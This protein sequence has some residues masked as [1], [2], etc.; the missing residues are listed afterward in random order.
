MIR[1]ALELVRVAR[2]AREAERVATERAR[3]RTGRRRSPRGRRRLRRAIMMVDARWTGGGNCFR[4]VLIEL[5]LDA[6]AARERLVFGLD[7]GRTGHV[8]FEGTEVKQ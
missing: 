6:G 2:V 8:A 3:G 1:L 4:R 7:I 5:A